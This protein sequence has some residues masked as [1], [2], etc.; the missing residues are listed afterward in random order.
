MQLGGVSL[1]LALVT[2]FM[3]F[4]AILYAARRIPNPGPMLSLILAME[5][6][7]IGIFAAQ[8]LMLFYVFFEDAL[9][10]RC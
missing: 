8:D 3:S 10:P 2:A 9:I 6:G 4:I 5:T 1:A 7:L